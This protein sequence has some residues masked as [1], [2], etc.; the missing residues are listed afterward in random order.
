MGK[1]GKGCSAKCQEQFVRSTRRAGA[2]K[3]LPDTYFSNVAK[4]RWQKPYRSDNAA[5]TKKDS[6]TVLG[7]DRD[8]FAAAR[9]LLV[10]ALVVLLAPRQASA[11]IGPGAGL[12]VVGSFF[13]VFVALCSGVLL[14]LTWPLR[15]LW[16]TL[17]R[18]RT[19]RGRVKRVVILGLDGMDY[20]LTQE[21]I[22]EGKLPHLA[23]LARHGCFKPLTATDAPN[24]PVA[25][26]SFQTG[27]NPDKHNLVDFLDPEAQSC[28]PA[29][30][31]VRS[32]P[33]WSALG[34]H[35]VF[36]CI[37]RVPPAFPPQRFRGVQLS[38]I[39]V[40]D[41]RGARGTF[42]YYTT[43]P[44]PDG[45]RIGDE[46][47]TVARCRNVVRAELAGP[48]NPRRADRPA[49]KIPFTVTIRDRESAVLKIAGARHELRQ[50]R[51]TDWIKVG[52]RHALGVKARGLCKF[53]LLGA[54]PEFQLYA[55]PVH[56]DPESPAMPISH[57][58]VYSVYLAKRQGPF[59][60]FGLAEDARA[61]SERILDDEHFIEQC[62]DGDREREAMF[63]DALDKVDRG[64]VVC[65]FDGADLLQR[66]FRR[67]IDRNHP[68]QSEI[69]RGTSRSVIEDHYR[70]MDD[71]VGRT[72]AR[73]AG[74]D[75]RLL[76][77]SGHGFCIDRSLMPGVLFCNRP[78]GA[79]APRLVDIGPTV[80]KLF[81]VP[82]PEYMDGRALGVGET[83]NI[84]PAAQNDDLP[85]AI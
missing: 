85:G 83:A 81:G 12:A 24:A 19:P 66:A 29:P 3:M 4:P 46:V 23:A 50:G 84:S 61:H 36:S 25:W 15:F 10:A 48:R 47:R 28:R 22:S 76:V 70:R 72:V 27:V 34:D 6:R 21:L 54:E 67:D 16:R 17:F 1:A 41:L 71:L 31:C 62:L 32:R 44:R 82:I 9:V 56:V 73:C 80:L 55:T 64:L 20:G 57:P 77:I 42:S 13:A 18:R 51:Y 45:E 39:D 60:T 63:F 78:V 43:K 65:V 5:D 35:G 58:A 52:F 37:L 53:L 74:D 68:V 7:S 2:R 33:F 79:E 14:L 49:P 69:S 59:A 30:K 11:Y 75:A 26:I 8:S 40:R 38:A